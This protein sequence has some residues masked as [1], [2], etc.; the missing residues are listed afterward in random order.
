VNGATGTMEK[1]PMPPPANRRSEGDGRSKLGTHHQSI[2]P[3]DP[4]NA[5]LR[6]SPSAAYWS[7]GNQVP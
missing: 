7:G 4:T 3:S 2:E 6:P 5:T 1:Q